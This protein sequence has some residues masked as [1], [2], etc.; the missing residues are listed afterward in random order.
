MGVHKDRF[1]VRFWRKQHPPGAFEPDPSR[2]NPPGLPWVYDYPRY[3]ELLERTMSPDIDQ[4][5]RMHGARPNSRIQ[6]SGDTA[7]NLLGLSTQVP[8]HGLFLGR[9]KPPVSD[10]QPRALVFKTVGFSKIPVSNTGKAACW[11]RRLKALRQGACS[12]AVIEVPCG[13]SWTWQTLQ[14]HPQ[15]TPGSVTGMDLSDNQAGCAGKV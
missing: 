12:P 5:T 13:R 3:S 11:C 4:V 6:P 8:G 9:P 15:R 7:L 10:R 2:Q 14:A 1:C